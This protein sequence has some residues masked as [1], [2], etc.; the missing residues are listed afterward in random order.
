MG[1]MEGKQKLF[2]LPEPHTDFIFAV[3]AEELGL[4][5]ALTV[6]ILFAIFLWRGTRAALRTQDNF[7]RFLAVGITSMI[8]LQAFINISVVLG[9][10]DADEG[11]S[12]AVCFLWGLYRRCL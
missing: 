12:A 8:V 7:G 5:G 11:N 9:M 2:Y 4:V 1:L 10:P 3:T 6:I